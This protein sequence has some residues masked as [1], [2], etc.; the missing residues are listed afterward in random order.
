ML[1]QDCPMP[2]SQNREKAEQLNHCTLEIYV[3]A[4]STKLSVQNGVSETK[5]SVSGEDLLLTIDKLS[6]ERM[7]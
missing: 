3:T 5:S 2:G 1:S 6:E 4:V 7:V